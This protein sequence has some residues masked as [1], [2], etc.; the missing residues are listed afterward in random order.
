MSHNSLDNILDLSNGLS[1]SLYIRKIGYDETKDPE[2][3]ATFNKDDA[4][5]TIW[6][7]RGSPSPPGSLEDTAVWEIEDLIDFNK[8]VNYINSQVKDELISTYTDSSDKIKKAT[9]YHLK[10]DSEN[11]L[12]ILKNII[13][14]SLPTEIEYYNKSHD[15][16]FEYRFFELEDPKKLDSGS[17]IAYKKFRVKI[18]EESIHEL[19]KVFIIR[20]KAIK[21]ILKKFIPSYMDTLVNYAYLN[22]LTVNELSLVYGKY[23]FYHDSGEVK[24]IKLANGKSI[25]IPLSFEFIFDVL[26]G[27]KNTFINNNR[28]IKN[29]KL[30][31][32]SLIGMDSG[33]ADQKSDTVTATIKNGHITNFD[34]NDVDELIKQ[35]ILK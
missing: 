5:E 34:I 16:H 21:D 31:F 7:K 26:P 3:G 27:N 6:V 28:M 30:R 1:E 14:N 12:K 4:Y 19:R 10:I 32:R 11:S 15:G 29:R 18:R 17:D 35:K 2:T 9:I 8:I 25:D 22:K 20:G 13:S 33:R 23:K 24:R